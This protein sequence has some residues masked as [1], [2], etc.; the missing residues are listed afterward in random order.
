MKE[1][2]EQWSRA[3]FDPSACCEHLNNNFSESLNNMI[4]NMI[5]KPICA[6]GMMYGQLVMGTMFKRRN[7]S[8]NWENGKLVSTAHDLIDEM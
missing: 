2:P 5:D 8:A 7:V 3:F 4:K 6:L 1:K